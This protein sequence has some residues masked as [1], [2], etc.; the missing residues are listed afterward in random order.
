MRVET[1]IFLI[2]SLVG[3][4]CSDDE[5][6]KE[7]EITDSCDTR[8]PTAPPYEPVKFEMAD[9]TMREGAIQ[10]NIWRAQ[11]LSGQP[12]ISSILLAEVRD[13]ENKKI[14]H[15]KLRT[16][17]RFIDPQV[18]VR[19]EDVLGY[20][21]LVAPRV[22][23]DVG[24]F[25]YQMLPNARIRGEVSAVFDDASISFEG[26]HFEGSLLVDCLDNYEDDIFCADS[27]RYALSGG[28]P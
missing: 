16:L 17:P 22:R 27:Y 3:A 5:P 8:P 12:S 10:W 14:V 25:K 19:L 26:A 9:G 21:F 23:T 13:T 7:C 15:L 20:A 6:I 2:G 4:A 18:D 11:D 24:R 1:L 28:V